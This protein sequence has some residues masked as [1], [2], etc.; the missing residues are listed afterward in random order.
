MPI[1][2]PPRV[3]LAGTAGHARRHLRRL[4]ELHDR[5]RV[6]LAGVCDIRDPDDEAL[7]LLPRGA[8]VHGHVDELLAACAPA[9]AVVATPPH[10]HLDLA[11]RVLC[12]GSDLLLEMPP[13]PDLGGFEELVALAERTGRACQVGFQSFGSPGFA[14]LRAAIDAGELGEVVGVGAVGAWTRTD[15]YYRRNAWAG[16]RWLDG[17]PVVDGVLTNPF[18][19]AV[20]S[21]LAVVGA[22]DRMPEEVTVELHRARDIEADDTSCV[23]IRCAGKPEVVVAGSLCAELDHEPYLVVHGTRGRAVLRYKTDLVQINDRLLRVPPPTDLLENLLDHRSDPHGVPLLS[24]LRNARGF[25]GVLQAVREAPDPVPIPAGWTRTEGCGASARR[26]IRGID[27]EV[28]AAAERLALFS[29]LG[30]PWAVSGAARC[31]RS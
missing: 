25:T 20:A 22:A 5:R 24:P 18:S 16:R 8:S 15:S 19:H 4:R 23:R 28:A 17:Q 30:V 27:V 3:V 26:V 10:T 21:A 7:A 9:V 12:H 14:V 2:D 29:E 11:R 13:V 6:V 1:T 31:V